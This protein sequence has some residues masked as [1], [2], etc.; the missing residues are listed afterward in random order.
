MLNKIHVLLPGAASVAVLVLSLI[1]AFPLHAQEA[2]ETATVEFIVVDG[3]T[4]PLAAPL[5]IVGAVVPASL[6]GLSRNLEM[7]TGDDLSVIPGRSFAEQLQSVPGVVVSQRRQHGVQSDLSIRG[8]SFEQVQVLMDGYDLSDAQTGHHLMDLPVGLGDIQRLE[9]L[10]GHGSVQ[11]GAGSFG[12]TVNVVTVRPEERNGGQVA[13]TG[14]G[15]GTWGLE[16]VADL[17][18]AQSQALRFSLEKFGTD[19]YELIQSDGTPID[20]ANDAD[21]WSGTGRVIQTYE[22]GEADVIFALSQRE[23]GALGFY[24]PYPSFEETQTLFAA[25]RVTHRVNEDLTIEPRVFLRRHEDRFVLFRENPASYTN[26]HLTRKFGS[27]VRGLL[28]LGH[29]NTLSLGVEGTYED[30]DSI[31]IRGGVEGPALG[32]HLRRR[33]AIAA[34]LDNNEGAALW[35][36]GARLDTRE[37]FAP[38]F[39]ATGAL[40]YLATDHL[41]MRGAV[42]SIH[43]IPSFTEL[44]YSSPTDLGDPGLEAESGW[45]YDLGVEYNQG[46]WRFRS[47][48]FQREE[49][50]VI[51][52]ARAANAD[53][54]WRSMNIADGRV[55]GLENILSW[56]HGG[57]HLISVGHSWLDKTLE[58]PHGFEGKYALLTPKHQIL[59]QGTMRLSHGLSLTLGGRYLERNDGPTDFRHLFVMDGR[60]DWES[61]KGYFVGLMATNILDRRYEEIP[62]VPMSRALLTCRVGARF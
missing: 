35:Q 15:Q 17:A 45:I 23:F 13:L 7:V 59:L 33:L 56:R 27:T 42:G 6:P 2:P 14:G 38:R 29:H 54:L 47:T 57:G 43:R 25:A 32:E 50:D 37:G 5:E 11:Y 31:G 51:E 20:G 9:V 61:G 62:G 44:Y 16:A 19:G 60:L 10:P 21:T 55:T 8:S 58:L 4:I 18:P 30:I 28:N 46:R 39:T 48:F 53:D 26:D 22:Q 41:T 1:P 49:Q 52:W 34:E 40:S 24:A 36:I 12:G 3:D